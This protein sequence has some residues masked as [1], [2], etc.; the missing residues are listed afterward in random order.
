MSRIDLQLV[1]THPDGVAGLSFLSNTLR[2]LTVFAA[3]HGTMVAGYLATR[4]VILG[5][6]LTE[7][8]AE[9]AAMVILVLFMTI[10][11]LFVFTPQLAEAKR[12][13]LREYGRLAMRYVSV[14]DAKW[15]RGT[16]GS[17]GALLGSADVQSLADMG[18]SYAVVRT[19]RTVPVTNDAIYRIAVATLAPIVP[20]LLTIMPLEELV[21]KLAAILF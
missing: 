16:S 2:A 20:L 21:K 7:F 1:P 10:S 6:P 5:G 3:A 8:K 12:N 9:I 13:G 15:V 17:S 11:P 19:M 14:F 4:T 18:N